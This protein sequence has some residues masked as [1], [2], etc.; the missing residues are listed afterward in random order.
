MAEEKKTL[1]QQFMEK[2]GV[3]AY[4]GG[5]DKPDHIQSR[6]FFG[7]L[8]QGKTSFIEKGDADLSYDI[9]TLEDKMQSQSLTTEAHDF[10]QNIEKRFRNVVPGITVFVIDPDAIKGHYLMDDGADRGLSKSLYMYVEDKLQKANAGDGKT[11][12]AQKEIL[13]M[14]SQSVLTGRNPFSMRAGIS[15]TYAHIEGLGAVNL[16][17]PDNPDSMAPNVLGDAV[18]GADKRMI[19]EGITP[20]EFR[21]LVVYHEL[22]HATDKNY[23]GYSFKKVTQNQLS[24]VMDRHRTECIA[25]AHAVLQL[26]RDYGEEGLKCAD[27]WGDC[28]IEYLRA[29]VDKRLEDT[30][31]ETKFFKKMREEIAKTTGVNPDDPEWEATF[32]QLMANKE[33]ADIID[34]LGSPLAYHT[35]DVVDATIAY[36]REAL[37]DGSL[38]KMSDAEVIAKAQYMS[39]TYGLTR[40]EMA[41]VSIALAE[42]TEHP[43]YKQMMERCSESRDKMAGGDVSRKDIDKHY[44][45][46]REKNAYIKALQFARNLGLPDPDFKMSIGLKKEIL[47]QNAEL[48]KFQ[49][50]GGQ[51]LSGYAA[52]VLDALNENDA[53]RE[54]MHALISQQKEELRAAG[55]DPENPDVYAEDKLRFLDTVIEQAPSIEAMVAGNK[56]VKEQIAAVET[57]TEVKGD[58]A[59]AHFVKNELA[60]LAAMQKMLAMAAQRNPQAMTLEQQYSA[61]AKENK[62]F[63]AA[64]AGEKETQVAAFAIR[65][66]KETWEKVSQDPVMAMLVDA[67]AKQKPTEFLSQYQMMAGNPDQETVVGLWKGAAAYHQAVVATVIQSPA[68]REAVAQKDPELFAAVVDSVKSMKSKGR[69]APTEIKQAGPLQPMVDKQVKDT[70]VQKQLKNKLA[71]RA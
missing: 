40:Q 22:G 35:T 48:Q 3:T 24:D 46:E 52:A 44:E 60:S 14:V 55:H 63:K 69:A 17:L 67:K 38:M 34:K 37:R 43:K 8:P 53:D 16:V 9:S 70:L 10:V 42:G 2:G 19:R 25:D 11:F 32:K 50:E 18:Y 59:I 13:D 6:P 26:A 20:D 68:I 61:M 39:E 65:S 23:C 62:L 28:R 4:E 45:I 57:D 15:P 36:A 33:T 64:I 49:A 66:D 31:Y 71:G 58:A 12:L 1:A 41:E 21:R 56:I 29:C 30:K 5:L 54:F 47:R 51:E 7:L 27:L